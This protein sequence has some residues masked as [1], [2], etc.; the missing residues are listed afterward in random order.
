MTGI[1]TSVTAQTRLLAIVLIMFVG[2]V[3]LSHSGAAQTIYS[4]DSGDLVRVTVFGE[5]DLS[6]E[7]S[8]DAQGKL[9]LALIGPVFVRGMTTSQARTAIHDAYLDGYLRHPDIA[10]DVVAFRPFFI[11]GEVNQPGSYSF[12][13]GMNVLNAIAIGGGMTYRGDEDDIEI[14]RGNDTARVSIPANLA[15]IVMPGDI[16][17]IAERYF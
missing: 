14:L 6:G 9:N 8:I 7:F 10:V 13:P 12:V 4:L 15:T 17:R 5:P 3:A 1:V 11:V 2:I 16:V